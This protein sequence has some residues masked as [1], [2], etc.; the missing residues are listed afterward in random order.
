MSLG[1]Q[2]RVGD[3]RDT[4]EVKWEGVSDGLNMERRKKQIPGFFLNSPSLLIFPFCFT[5]L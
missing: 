4:W 2:L 1:R 3:L 5:L